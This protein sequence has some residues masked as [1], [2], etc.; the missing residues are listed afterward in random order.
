MSNVKVVK[1]TRIISKISELSV[2]LGFVF[3]CAVKKKQVVRGTRIERG[4]YWRM[5]DSLQ[6]GRG[7][8]DAPFISGV[9]PV[10][11]FLLI[12]AVFEK[13]IE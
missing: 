12:Y 13:E 5:R 9:S 1:L 11:F 2:A 6:R 8:K 3:G 7:H 10:C 4:N